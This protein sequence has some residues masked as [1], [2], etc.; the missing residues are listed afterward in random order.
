M[1]DKKERHF[2]PFGVAVHPWITRADTKF[3]TD[4][5]FKAGLSCDPN[6]EE[7]AAFIEKL[8]AELDA[9]IAG[10]G[11]G[12]ITWQGAKLKAPAKLKL[13]K[14]DLYSEEYE[15]EEGE[16]EPT[17]NIILR[18]K[19]KAIVRYKDRKTGEEK[20]IHKK[21]ALVDAQ[22]RPITGG[23]AIYG[24]SIVRFSVLFS[25]WYR[26]TD[27]ACGV[28]LKP[29]ACQIKELV[30]GDANTDYGFGA[31]D[32]YTHE[33]GSAPAA[34]STSSGAYEDEPEDEDEVDF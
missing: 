27:G 23:I 2:T 15:G 14:A 21:I 5:V 24:G 7:V 26:A 8:D 25:P 4:G 34:D 32:G 30:S 9:F 6:D 12:S 20:E 33:S 11:D 29:L 13:H 19:Q 10:L 16:E 22:G 1:A 18:V 3:D 31:V 17:G 28:S